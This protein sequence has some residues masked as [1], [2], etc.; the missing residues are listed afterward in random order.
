MLNRYA[1]TGIAGVP[2]ARLDEIQPANLPC[3]RFAGQARTPA[4]PVDG[5]SQE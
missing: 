2:P 4:I 3:G 1:S 5:R